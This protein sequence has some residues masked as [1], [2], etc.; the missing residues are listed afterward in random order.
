MHNDSTRAGKG[1]G[2]DWAPY[3]NKL[4]DSGCFDGGSAIGGGVCTNKSDR[5]VAVTNHLVGY[6]LVRADD[7]DHA[8]SLVPGNPVFEAGGTVEIRELSKG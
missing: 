4:R 2:A 6:L 3:L 5:S 8:R 7:L 1:D